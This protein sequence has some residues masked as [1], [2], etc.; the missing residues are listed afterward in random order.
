MWRGKAQRRTGVYSGSCQARHQD[1]TEAGN[2]DTVVQTIHQLCSAF[3]FTR[4]SFHLQE[5]TVHI[6]GLTPTH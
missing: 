6:V 2:L 1:G 5:Y 3:N 4:T